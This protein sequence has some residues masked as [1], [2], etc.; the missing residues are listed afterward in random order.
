LFQNPNASLT[1]NAQQSLF[2][3]VQQLQP[4]TVPK[5]QQVMVELFFTIYRLL[6]EIMKHCLITW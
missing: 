6:S 2:L 5:W 3:T 1:C 4:L